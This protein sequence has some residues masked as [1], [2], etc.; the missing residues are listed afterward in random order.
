MTGNRSF[1]DDAASGFPTPPRSFADRE[2]REIRIDGIDE[3]DLDAV[4]EMYV[5]FDPADRAQGIPPAGEERVYDWLDAI[6]DDGINVAAFHGDD[7]AG[8][9]TLVPDEAHGEP[10][11]HAYELAI[12][13]LQQ[14]QRAGIGRELLVTLLG[15]GAREGVDRVWLT[16]ERWNTAAVSLYRDVGFETCGSESFELEMSLRLAD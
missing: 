11:E 1:P 2:D 16:V 8:H 6:F 15:H 9:A 4:A 7:V 5:E 12:F 3:S 13:V 10:G 14:Y